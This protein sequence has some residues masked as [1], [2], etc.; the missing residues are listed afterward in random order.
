M[1][2]QTSAQQVVTAGSIPSR[3]PMLPFQTTLQSTA[4]KVVVIGTIG[5]GSVLDL[6][7]IESSRSAWAEMLD[8]IRKALH[9]TVTQ[10]AAALLVERQS[11]YAWS[12]G[13]KSPSAKNQ[14]RIAELQE[15]SHRLREALGDRLAPYLNRELYSLQVSFWDA[16]SRGDAPVAL[17]STVIAEAGEHESRRERLRA[18]IGRSLSTKP[19]DQNG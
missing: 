13:E 19:L 4:T 5:T 3:V 18:S 9:A 2:W 8:D 14:R 6:R 11:V 7:V 17:A 1:N 10:L 15:A 12:R 16:L